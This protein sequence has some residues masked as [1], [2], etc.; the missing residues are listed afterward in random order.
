MFL[1]IRSNNIK[2][3]A[4]EVF[5]TII[6]TAVIT[7]SSKKAEKLPFICIT[8]LN[9]ALLM[10]AFFEYVTRDILCVYFEVKNFKHSKAMEKQLL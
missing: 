7:I 5:S 3:R 4:R 8:L 9:P 6:T 1:G 10:S 2:H